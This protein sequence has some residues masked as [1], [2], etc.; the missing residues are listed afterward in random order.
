VVSGHALNISDMLDRSKGDVA[1]TMLDLDEA[2]PVS[3]AQLLENL[4][5]VIRVRVIR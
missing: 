1:Y 5:G 4:D 3:L 2:T